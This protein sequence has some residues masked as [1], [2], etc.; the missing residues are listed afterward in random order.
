MSKGRYKAVI[1]AVVAVFAATAVATSPAG[2]GDSG[3]FFVYEGGAQLSFDYTRMESATGLARTESTTFPADPSAYECI[4]LSVNDVDWTAGQLT[5]LTDYVMDGGRLIAVGDNSNF[6]GSNASMNAVSTA[7]GSGLSIR[8]AMIDVSYNVT[9]NVRVAPPYSTGLSSIVMGATSEVLIGGSGVA[10]LGTPT[11][12]IPMIGAEVLGHGHF[13]LLGDGNVLSDGS[14]TGYTEH[15][16]GVLAA[17]L[18]SAPIANQPPVADAG[19][20]QTVSGPPDAPVE[21]TLDGSGSSDP[22]GDMITYEWTGPF[23]GGTASGAAPTV[24]FA[25]VGDHV[26]TLT[27]TDEFGAEST[28]TVVISVVH[29]TEDPPSETSTTTSTTAPADVGS[30]TNTAP[31]A[32]PTRAQPTFTG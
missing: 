15:D 8:D 30:D 17:N 11:D 10:V 9:T 12:D 18:C 21:A 24:A 20:D 28:D 26:V 32:T 1:G 19:D 3:A 5:A 27:V 22:D 14:S 6:P 29:L 25:E 7:L 23:D 2:A 13:V 4:V 16:N 31:P